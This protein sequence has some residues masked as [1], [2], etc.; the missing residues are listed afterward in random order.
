VGL[1]SDHII[2]AEDNPADIFLV[3]ES[4]RQHG[5]GCELDI[6]SDG[7]VALRMIDQFD[8]NADAPHV[9]AI[10]LD[11]NLP[12]CGGEEIIQ[13]LRQSKK[14][15]SVPVVI[16]TSSEAPKDKALVGEIKAGCYF[17]KSASLEEFLQLGAVVKA[18]MQRSRAATAEP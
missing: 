3:K 17:R 10:V 14:L 15:I 6:A 1:E 18:M 4:F 2:L 12:K 9:A 7:E 16:M 11:L 13:R 8:A 5:I